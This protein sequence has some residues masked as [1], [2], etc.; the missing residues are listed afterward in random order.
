[1]RVVTQQL[2]RYGVAVFTT[3]AASLLALVLAPLSLR[4]PFALFAAAVVVSSLEGGLK[5][6][7]LA[8]ALATLAL[9]VEYWLLPLAQLP[10]NQAELAPLL[11]L[12]VIV[13]LLSNYLGKQCWQAVHASE[14][15]Q[16][17]LA[18]LG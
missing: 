7:L 1:M 6:G 18:N 3:A 9:A 16:A 17:T 5:P 15:M 4:V 13:S 12:F 14:Q 11:I 10:E 8:T 2:P